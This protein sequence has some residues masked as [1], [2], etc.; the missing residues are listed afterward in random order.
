MP[1]L[2]SSSPSAKAPDGWKGTSKTQPAS[3]S[4]LAAVRLVRAARWVLPA[5]LDPSSRLIRREGRGSESVVTDA[6]AARTSRRSGH[7]MS[8]TEVNG[9]PAEARARRAELSRLENEARYAR[10]RF[11]LYRAMAHGPRATS[12]FRLRELQRRASSAEA[13]L[14]RARG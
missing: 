10:D 12:T 6:R 14:R 9:N 4:I 11:R 7:D 3:T 5:P 13:R 8:S 1:D 2:A